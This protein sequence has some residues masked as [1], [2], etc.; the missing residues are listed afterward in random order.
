MMSAMANTTKLLLPAAMARIG[1]DLLAKR[2]DVQAVPFDVNMPTAGFHA[3]LADVEGVALIT[4]PFGEAEIQA[5]PKLRVVARHGVGYD[6]VDVAALTRRGIP[7]M[8]TG[9]A[10]SPSVAEHALY[11]MLELAKG[12]G[13]RNAMVRQGRWAERLSGELPIDLFG[14]TLLIVGFG[15]SGVRVAKA[16]LALGMRVRVFDPYVEAG[17]IT[18]AGCAPE[19]ELDAALPD[20]DFV[21]IHC[22]KT[23]GTQGMFDGARLGRMKPT[24]YLVSTARGGIID[25]RRS[26]RR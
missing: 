4:T 22:P 25:Q 20:A 8:V 13:P 17:A 5:A 6:A 1:W 16:C 11:L 24:A 19:N 26:I 18:A 3:L 21:S 10:N 9:D 12:G 2:G 23:T 14:K 7:L 15:R